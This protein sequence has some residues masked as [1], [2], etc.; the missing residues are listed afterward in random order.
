MSYWLARNIASSLHGTVRTLCVE[1]ATHKCVG[2]L[3]QA[4][5]KTPTLGGFKLFFCHTKAGRLTQ[6]LA[7]AGRNP[8]SG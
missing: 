7:F 3:L 1:G 4:I 6:I 5:A 8:G 2:S